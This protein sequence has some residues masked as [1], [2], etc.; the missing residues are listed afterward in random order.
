MEDKELLKQLKVLGFS[1]FEREE[2]ADA[3]FAL[4]Q[5]TK[6]KN[7]RLWEGL[8][9][10]LANSAK[11]G[12][13]DYDKTVKYLENP[14]YKDSFDELL[15]MSLALYKV[16]KLKVFWVEK[17][18]QGYPVNKKE[19]YFYFL[20]KL[21]RDQ[22]FKVAGRQMDSKRLKST[23]NN[24]YSSKVQKSVGDLLSKREEFDLEYCLTQVFSPK[25]KELFLKK[26]RGQKLSKTEKEY[27]SRV[28]R[29]KVKALANSQLHRLAQKLIE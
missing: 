5:M 4:A 22:A 15:G 19:K 8:P 21:K 14:D 28:V 1:L 10:V 24:Y 27:F 13:F 16:L 6:S 2:R 12:L 9:V 23:F 18:V 25:Q 7:L 29:K 17:L 26:L 20:N 3:N 11:K